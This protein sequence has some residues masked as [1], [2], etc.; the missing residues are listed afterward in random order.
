MGKMKKIMVA[1]AVCYVA[2]K[3]GKKYLRENNLTVGDVADRVKAKAEEFV[4]QAVGIVPDTGEEYTTGRKIY[5]FGT[6][7][8]IALVHLSEGVTGL[9]DNKK[10]YPI[11]KKVKS[12]SEEGDKL[13]VYSDQADYVLHD[14]PFFM[15]VYVKEAAEAETIAAELGAQYDPAEAAVYR[16]RAEPDKTRCRNDSIPEGIAAFGGKMKPSAE[17]IRRLSYFGWGIYGT[18]VRLRSYRCGTHQKSV[19]AKGL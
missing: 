14:A 16:Y 13:Y 2:Y 17:P 12:Y 8:R 7:K 11:E 15:N 10:N 6:E 5:T 1:G 9:Y 18:G 3:L 19:E 4:K